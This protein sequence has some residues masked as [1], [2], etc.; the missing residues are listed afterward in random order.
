[1]MILV[2]GGKGMAGHMVTSYLKKNT[3]YHISH[4]SRDCDDTEGYYLDVMDL[5]RVRELILSKKP[6]VIINCAG[7]LNDFAERHKQQA[8]LVNSFIPHFVASLLDSY[9]GKLIHISTDCVFTGDQGKYTETAVPD[10]VT[11]YARTKMLGE[12]TVGRHLTLRTSIVGPELKNG[13]GLLH[14]FMNQQGNIKGFTNVY[15]NGITTLE[16]AKAI[17]AS[18]EQDITGL[19]QLTSPEIVSKYE[20]LKRFQTVF[21]KDDVTIHPFQTQ[22]CDKSLLNTRTDFQYTVPPN[23]EM[24]TELRDWMKAH[25]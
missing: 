23:L 11:I 22:F 13:I 7:I 8:I 2:L 25:E 1:M 24:I 12:V 4:T 10:G 15:W 3:P 19:Y 20:L 6:D 18:I 5:E 14:W 16:L 9:G 17:A 21:Q